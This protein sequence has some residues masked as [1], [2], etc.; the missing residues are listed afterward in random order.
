MIVTGSGTSLLTNYINM[1]WD[2]VKP[3]N[4]LTPI[5]G[6]FA[7][8]NNETDWRG[9]AVLAY[10]DL[11]SAVW[12]SGQTEDIFIQKGWIALQPDT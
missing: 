3:C 2:G 6:H 8:K 7:F 5:A 10:T 11:N 1:R 9:S 12:G 4:A